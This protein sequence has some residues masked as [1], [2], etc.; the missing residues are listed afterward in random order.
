MDLEHDL[1]NTMVL[2]RKSRNS[3]F[4]TNFNVF[5][6]FR[7]RCDFVK[8]SQPPCSFL[9]KSVNVSAPV[10]VFDADGCKNVLGGVLR[11]RIRFYTHL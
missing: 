9:L 8:M 5:V 11:M 1:Q 3:V 10:L 2:E 7:R 6:R 4:S